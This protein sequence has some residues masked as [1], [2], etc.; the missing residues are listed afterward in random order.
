MDDQQLF[1]P[2]LSTTTISSSSSATLDSG[3]DDYIKMLSPNSSV[4]IILRLFTIISIGF[5]SIWAN[6]ESS[7]GFDITVVNDNK[8]SSEGKRFT[9]LYMSNDKAVR[10]IQN[11]SSFVE[12]ILYPNRNYTK[13]KIHHVTLRLA[14]T[15]N[16]TSVVTVETKTN[17]EFVINVSLSIGVT[18]SV[19]CEIISM[20]L[21][22]M[23]RIW[24]WNCESRA[25]P[26]LLDGLVEYIKKVSGFSGWELELP[27]FGHFC[28]GDKNPK[29]VAQFLDY[30]EKHS[31]SFI[32]RLNR[33]L[34][35]G[36]DDL[37]VED[38]LGMQRHK[39]SK[40]EIR[41]TI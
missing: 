16:L 1:Q 37:T 5:I 11:T 24:L 29:A 28:L 30:C 20:I 7:K 10:I 12:N 39:R 23:A 15:N 8:D 40:E 9:L 13:K 17:D 36:W 32:R 31:K 2:L 35:D 38:A 33:G 21:Q 6:Y 3:E 34:K 19:D 18:K 26:W 22:G 27:E 25:P 41:I 4:N 14:K